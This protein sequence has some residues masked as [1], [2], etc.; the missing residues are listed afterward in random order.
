M[1]KNTGDQGLLEELY[2]QVV[3]AVQWQAA[4]SSTWGLIQYIIDTYDILRL[5]VY[6]LATFNGFLHLLAMRAGAYLATEMGD[7]ATAA[8]A[9]KA[10]DAGSAAA[11]S[12]LWNSTYSYFRAYWTNNASEPGDAIMADCLYGQMLSLHHGLGWLVNTSYVASHLAAET[13]YNGND[14]GFT[15]GRGAPAA[16]LVRTRVCAPPAVR[17]VRRR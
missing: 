8:A 14:Y 3:K 2:P 4:Q 6:P 15:V 1:Y 17:A 10:F 16:T 13:T 7:T 9:T 12:L 5:D 11:T